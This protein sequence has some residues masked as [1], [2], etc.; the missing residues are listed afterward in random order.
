[1]RAALRL[2]QRDGVLAGL[3]LCEVAREAGVTPANVYHHFGSRRSLLRA[4]IGARIPPAAPDDHDPPAEERWTDRIMSGFDFVWA[5]PELCLFALLAVDGDD[6]FPLDPHLKV[7]RVVFERDARAG[8]LR[9]DVDP[10]S[11]HITMAASI[12]GLVLF[13]E[14][15]A[16]QI[17]ISMEEFQRRARAVFEAMAVGF[18][19]SGEDQEAKSA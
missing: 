11:V 2:L 13:R 6:E 10:E 9:A 14:A 12:F 3:N 18:A 19:D 8:R 1:M 7:S 4:A 15:A 17:G 5:N 16:R